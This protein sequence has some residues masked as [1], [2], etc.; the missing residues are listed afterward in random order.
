MRLENY[1]NYRKSNVFEA[2]CVPC[3]RCRTRGGGR[4][5]HKCCTLVRSNLNI[6][7]ITALMRAGNKIKSYGK[8]WVPVK[9]A[10]LKNMTARE[11]SVYLDM[12]VL[13]SSYRI[14]SMQ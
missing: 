11:G 13:K 3:A 4:F 12:V 14:S 10:K 8:E 2:V 5:S 6:K 7:N 9:Y 1:K